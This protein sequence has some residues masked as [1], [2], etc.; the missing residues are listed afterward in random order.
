[1]A[2]NRRPTAKRSAHDVQPFVPCAFL[3]LHS[4]KKGLNVGPTWHRND[5]IMKRASVKKYVRAE[6]HL[7]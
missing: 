7:Q 3:W 6:V 5:K 2:S 1:V 4:E